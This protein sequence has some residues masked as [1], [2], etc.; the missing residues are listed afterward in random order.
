MN[1]QPIHIYRHRVSERHIGTY[2]YPIVIN[3]EEA[4]GDSEEVY[5]TIITNDDRVATIK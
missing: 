3:K 2:M 4:G 1:K 5:T